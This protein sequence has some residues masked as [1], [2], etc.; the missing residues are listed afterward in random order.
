MKLGI[1]GLPQAGKTT[2]FNALTQRS[3]EPA[4]GGGK[5]NAVQGVV[6]VPDTRVD[7]LSQHYQPKK[8]T[9]AQVTYIDL[10]AMPGALENK[11]EYMAQLLIH[12]RPVDALLMVVRN[13]P[14]AAGNAP[15]PAGDCRE[16]QDEFLLADLATIE[17]RL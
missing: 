2:I 6:T 4:T 10:Q 14:D 9:Y 13:F 16:L 3:G 17:K 11:Q 12:M 5:V 7:W 1:V 8:T 15:D